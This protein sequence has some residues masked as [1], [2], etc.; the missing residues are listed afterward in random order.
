V[1]LFKKVH[2][3]YVSEVLFRFE[4][5]FIFHWHL[6]VKNVHILRKS[7]SF[8]TGKYIKNSAYPISVCPFITFE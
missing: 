1:Y 7:V 5:D 6:C 4:T 8:P 2:Y 3:P